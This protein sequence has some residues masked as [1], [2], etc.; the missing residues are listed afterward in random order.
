MGPLWSARQ[1]LISTR[2]GH[3]LTVPPCTAAPARRRFRAEG[4]EIM[5]CRF[6]LLAIIT[7]QVVTHGDVKTNIHNRNLL[8]VSCSTGQYYESLSAKCENCPNF[9]SAP[10]GSLNVSNC[11]CILGYTGTNGQ[12]CTACDQGKYKSIVGSLPCT[13]CSSG[14][15]STGIGIS[16]CSSCI[17][18]SYQNKTG[19]TSCSPCMPGLFR[20][21]SG[22]LQCSL[23]EK[24][25]FQSA[26]GA[27]FCT[28]CPKG[29][30]SA[31]GSDNFF[32]CTCDFGYSGIVSRVT[33]ICY[34]CVAGKYKNVLGTSSCADCPN[35][36]FSPA[37]SSS[38]ANCSCNAGYFR[39]TLN[40]CT[41]C[42]PGTHNAWGEPSNCT[43]CA[44]HST[45]GYGAKSCTCN[46]GFIKVADGTGSCVNCAAGKYKSSEFECSLCSAG[47]YRSPSSI[48]STAGCQSCPPGCQSSCCPEINQFC[49]DDASLSELKR[50]CV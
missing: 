11:S 40:S 7:H 12:I 15:F 22:S 42:L 3:R 19:T 37:G 1:L 39:A 32:N 2:E 44:N 50:V 5:A 6:L 47:K 31:V 29:S 27:S 18:G 36:S 17:P 14:T 38:I 24:G 9:T 28:T 45:S 48:D 33:V 26:S 8:E 25:K 46:T 4:R 23:C 21:S 41:P 34:I 10:S 30:T 35:D 16:A 43:N 20:S 13:S 49:C